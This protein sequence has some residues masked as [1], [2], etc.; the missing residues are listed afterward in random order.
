MI[1]NVKVDDKEYK[2][3]IVEGQKTLE[4]Y[5]DG[6]NIK[7]DNNTIKK[8]RLNLFFQDNKPYEL[9]ISPND[10]GYHC[11]LNSR[12]SSCEVVD[13]KT[14][15]FAK[16]M[17]NGSRAKKRNTLKAPM[18]GLVVRIEIE[19]GA[20]VNKGDGLVVIEAM[21]MENELKASRE[22]KIKAIK[23]ELGQAVEK[24][25]VLIEFE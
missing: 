18:P 16:L 19:P 17:G 14:A 9:Q 3:E 21:K 2:L 7:T 15:R 4:V 11:W 23:I 5:L 1:Y 10:T 8:D 24:N 12:M 13:E 6:R 22:G 20:E 25:Q